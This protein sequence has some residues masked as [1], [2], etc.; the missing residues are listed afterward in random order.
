MGSDHKFITK[1]FQIKS[2]YLSF[3]N[4]LLKNDDHS[5]KNLQK[6]TLEMAWS[7]SSGITGCSEITES[8]E[9][10]RAS[11]FL[12]KSITTSISSPILSCLNSSCLILNGTSSRNKS[13]SDTISSPELE[14]E[15]VLGETDENPLLS[16]GHSLGLRIPGGLTSGA[17]AADDEIL[18]C[19]PR[20][21][22]IAAEKD[23]GAPA[24]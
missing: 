11:G 3:L 6:S 16:A 12:P 8:P 7:R 10:N 13:M 23:G 1:N 21:R 5:F 19:P 4:S 14:V 20:A 15:A 17:G 22:R 24:R 18:P 2:H 9:G